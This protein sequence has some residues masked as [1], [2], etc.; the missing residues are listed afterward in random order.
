MAFDRFCSQLERMNFLLQA[1]NLKFL[2]ELDSVLLNRG[3]KVVI[4]TP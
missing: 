2:F 4:N 3:F 1:T